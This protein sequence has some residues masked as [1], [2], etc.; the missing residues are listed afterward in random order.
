MPVMTARRAAELRRQ[1]SRPAADPD[2]RCRRGGSRVHRGPPHGP[3]RRE[4]VR[5][6]VAR[7]RVHRVLLRQRER[8]V[9]EERRGGRRPVYH[10]LP[11][12]LS[13]RILG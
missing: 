8:Q 2:G 12:R 7:R 5:R 6:G 1:V 4:G 11:R 9:H 13:T 10:P 3:R